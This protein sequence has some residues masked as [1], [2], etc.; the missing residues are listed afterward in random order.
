MPTTPSPKI[1][2]VGCG[3]WGSNHARTLSELGALY[4][5]SDR[6]EDRAEALAA[7]HGA[8]PIGIDA[9]LDDAAIDGLVLA[10]P[11]QYHADLAVEALA[12]GK[13]VL[14]E[15]PLALSVA[16]ARRVVDAAERSGLVAMTGHVLRFHP[17]FEALE[18][19]MPKASWAR[20]AI[21]IRTGWDWANFTPKTTRCGTSPR[22]IC[23]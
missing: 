5:V 4:G 23:R 10:L 9:L 6:H 20:C 15:K 19:L 12:A 13:H 11:P 7:R 2:V 18:A 16:D 22:M 17:A 14:V 8:R 1:A 21:S 3:Y